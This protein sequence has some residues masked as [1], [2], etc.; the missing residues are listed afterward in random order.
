MKSLVL[1]LLWSSLINF[2]DGHHW[3]YHQV[4][5]GQWDMTLYEGWFFEPSRIFPQTS[6]LE[7]SS[8]LLPRWVASMGLW[9]GLQLVYM[10]GQNL[11]L[12][13]YEFDIFGLPT[14]SE[15]SMESTFQSI[16]RNGLL[17]RSIDFRV[18]PSDRSSK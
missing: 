1:V 15:G 8:I 14:S 9:L 18:L 12:D 10:P 3:N 6:S 17:I 13:P 16:L 5:V 11:H 2:V 4:A 7:K